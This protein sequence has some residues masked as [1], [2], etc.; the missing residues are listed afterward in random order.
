[1]SKQAARVAAVSG[2]ATGIGRAVAEALA[3]RGFA[4]AVGGR[5]EARV[6]EAATALEAGGARALGLRL[7]VSD[8]DAVEAFYAGV[9]KALG[10]VDLVVN[11][12][13]HARPGRLFEKPP[14]EIRA[15]IETGLIGTLLFSRR[16]IAAMLERELPGDAVFVSSTSAETPWPWL[17]PYAASKAGIEQAVRSVALECEGTGVRCLVVRV[18]NTL[19]TEWATEW[20][21]EAAPALEAWQRLGLIRHAGL[22]R[23]EQVALALV[24]A[25]ETPRGV[26]LE[27]VSVHPEAPGDEGAG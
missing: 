23:P 11:C 9:E 2:G 19:G 21:P 13:G 17:A 6:Q 10:P 12:A 1:M 4:V 27:H 15:E 18:G 26:H 3:A 5:R 22:L 20:G 24:Q 25:V 8:A 14:E 7:D 16:G